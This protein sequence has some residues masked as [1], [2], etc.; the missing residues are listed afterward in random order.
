MCHD[1]GIISIPTTL[2]RFV[3]AIHKNKDPHPKQMNDDLI[4]DILFIQSE[5]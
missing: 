4:A 2:H 1:D 5:K 3:T